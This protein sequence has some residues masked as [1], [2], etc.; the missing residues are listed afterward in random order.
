MT[1]LSLVPVHEVRKHLRGSDTPDNRHREVMSLFGTIDSETPREAKGI[2]FRLD[3]IPGQA[4]TYLIR[5]ETPIDMDTPGARSKKEPEEVP[6]SGTTIQFRIAVNGI[7]RTNR[8]TAKPTRL[9]DQPP[10]DEDDRT[11]TISEWLGQRLTGALKDVYISNHVREVLGADRRG[12]LAGTGKVIQIDTI[13]G[14]AVVDDETI[15]KEKLVKGVGRAK[16]Y[17]CGLLTIRAI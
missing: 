2:L 1:Y 12:R 16:S 8:S 17:G 11:I 15:L 14:V 9:D 10:V 6:P 3:T 4:P 7:Q 5:S 13:D